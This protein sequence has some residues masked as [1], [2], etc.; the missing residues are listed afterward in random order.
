MEQA[1]RRFFS[2]SEDAFRKGSSG[3][4]NDQEEAYL[5]FNQAEGNIKNFSV[6]L[7]ANARI[8]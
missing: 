4:Y 5:G 1:G 7:F 2:Q 6:M 3:A 8:W